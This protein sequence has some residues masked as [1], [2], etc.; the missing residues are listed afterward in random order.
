MIVLT[1]CYML[2]KQSDLDPLVP[3]SLSE[4]HIAGLSRYPTPNILSCRLKGSISGFDS[5]SRS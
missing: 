1:A 5:L 4:K 3:Y 2:A